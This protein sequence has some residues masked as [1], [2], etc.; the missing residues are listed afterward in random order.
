MRAELLG[1]SR[2]RGAAVAIAGPTGPVS[3]V[4]WQ[5]D[6]GYFVVATGPARLD[7]ISVEAVRDWAFQTQ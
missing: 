6:D 4:K 5:R 3:Q 2:T 7:G 1:K